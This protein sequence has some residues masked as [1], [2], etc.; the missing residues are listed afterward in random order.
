[1][2]L[3]VREAARLLSVS[4]SEVY[5][6]VEDGDIPFIV[7]NHHPL[8]NREELLEWATARHMPLSVELFADDEGRPPL[9][10]DALA[11]G[12]VHHG[13]AGTDVV[14]CLRG[15]VACLPIEDDGDRE[16][17]LEIMRAREAQAS[18]GVGRGIAIP[19]V[20]APLV[21]AGCPP[22]IALCFLAAP[23]PF[24]AIDKEPVTTVF[25]MMTPTVRV[26]L[27][28]LSRLSA[29]LHDAGFADAIRRRADAATVLVEAQ[30]VDAAMATPGPSKT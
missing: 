24:E 30:R 3:G 10:A 15:I 19:H 8:F 11:A 25:A 6:W 21:F 18:T 20:R 16:M 13:V 17:V 4:E 26:H 5:H 23:V 9:L 12:G 2:K 14:S 27:Q 28:L 1:M 22:A 29:A 7:V